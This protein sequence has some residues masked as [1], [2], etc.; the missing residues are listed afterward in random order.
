MARK[1]PPARRGAKKASERAPRI[2]TV[3]AAAGRVV[4]R[5]DAAVYPLDAVY[6]AAYEMLDRA[7]VF[8]GAV[9][10]GVAVEL[11]RK[12]AGGDLEA[13]AGD[14]GDRLLDHALRVSLAREHGA[15]RELIVSRALAGAGGAPEPP[16]RASSAGPGDPFDVSDEWAASRDR[17]PGR[18]S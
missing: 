8:L 1:R 7:W 2:L 14:F 12:A 6:G 5:V 4:V 10:G 17:P 3:D 18:R 15:M 13:L 11:R 16:D 9:K